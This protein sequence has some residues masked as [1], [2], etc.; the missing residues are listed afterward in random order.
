MAQ[1]RPRTPDED[2]IS[3][4]FLVDPAKAFELWIASE[5]C[6]KTR[7]AIEKLCGPE[8]DVDNV[9]A[10][11]NYKAFRS[12]K[13]FDPSRASFTTWF[14]KIVQNVLKSALR[15][16]LQS[17]ESGATQ[18]FELEMD[19]RRP[20]RPTTEELLEPTI[21]NGPSRWEVYWQRLEV[22]IGQLPDLERQVIEA[23]LRQEPLADFARRLGKQP[24]NIY[25]SKHKAI[26]KL[27]RWANEANDE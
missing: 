16:K 25:T 15:K 11:A 1:K 19:Q 13:T 10:D 6:E 23:V 8:V 9:F 26:A 3:H 18:L 20:R 21:A 5:A 27:R 24:G 22:L 12:I 17:V 14:R 4:L 2:K 7:H